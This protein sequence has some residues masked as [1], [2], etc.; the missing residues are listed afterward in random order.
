MKAKCIVLLLMVLL[1]L[2]VLAGADTWTVENENYLLAIDSQ[3]MQLE[4][5]NKATGK[6]MRSYTDTTLSKMNKKWQGFLASTV[7]IEVAKGSSANTERLDIQSENAKVTMTAVENGADFLVDFEK[8]GQRLQVQI[9]LLEDGLSVTVPGDSIEEYGETSLCGVYIL[10]AFGATFQKEHE[11]YMLIPEA[12]GAIINLSDGVGMGNTPYTKKFFGSN[13]GVDRTTTTELNRPAQDALLPVYGMAYTD[14]QQGYLA[15]VTKGADSAEM[16]AYPGGVIT[17]YNWLG[18]RFILREN[19][20]Y[21]V[22]RASGLTSREAEANLRDMQV[23]FHL[24]DGEDATYSGMAARYRQ[25]L[26]E[27]GRMPEGDTAYRPRIAFLGAESQEFLLWD[28]LVPMTS[29]QEAKDILTNLCGRGLTPPMVVYSGWQKGGLTQQYGSGAVKAEGKLGGNG[30]LEELQSA[31]KDLGGLFLLEQDPVLANPER[32]YNTRFDVVRTLGRVVAQVDTGMDRYPRLY[33]LTPARS[34]ELLMD[35]QEAWSDAI[36]GLAV[37]T[38][39]K[40][41]FSCYLDG[42]RKVRTWTQQQYQDILAEL[43]RMSLALQQPMVEYW[44]SMDYYLDLPL[45]TTSYSFITAEVPFLPLILNGSV[46][47]WAPYANDEANVE[48]KLLKTLE[49]GAYPSWML[50]ANDV[51]DLSETNM[52]DLFCAKW[53]VLDDAIL[54]RDAELRGMYEQL[55]GSRMVKHEVLSE[56]L[57][58]VTYDTGLQLALNYGEQACVHQGTTIDPMSYVLL[59][60]GEQP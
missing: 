39:P 28:Q 33:Y 38:L 27:E 53:D 25:Y 47:Y 8:K 32:T 59:G 35:H 12:S 24:L 13:V 14:T 51:K 20:I 45:D 56:T 2:P 31:V 3:T 50:T 19:Y 36:P 44:T 49:Y 52:C 58:L 55:R 5:T 4:I 48:E 15:I 11:G 16:N 7:A 60:G 34:R 26:T 18:T 30:G 10:P 57:R 29:F 21:Q 6:A 43:D 46:A 22:S 54:E 40:V 23:C 37:N 41:L 9:R 42:G 17:D 1:C